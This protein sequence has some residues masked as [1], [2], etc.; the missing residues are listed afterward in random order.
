MSQTWTDDP[1]A[2]GHVGQTDLQNMENNFLAIKSMFSGASAP[3]N[4]VAGMP[5]FDTA[6]KVLKSRN[7]SNNAWLGLFH[8]DASQKIL[9]YDD[10]VLD[11]YA[12]D[13]TVTDKVIALKGGATYVAGGATAGSWTL[14]AHNHQWY[15]FRAGAVDDYSYNSAGTNTVIGY[16]VAGGLGLS[17]ANVGQQ[18]PNADQYTSN[19]TQVP[20]TDRP[21]AA[22]VILVY[23]DL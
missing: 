12:R 22:V 18:A 8:G 10:D 17:R 6:Q 11:G 23:L 19:H 16:A 2:S 15:D 1:F 13:D 4:P 21:A 14:T 20:S 9:V 7:N 3:S 5:W